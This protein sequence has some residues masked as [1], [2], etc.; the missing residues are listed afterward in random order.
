M[1][2]PVFPSYA[3]LLFEGYGEQREPGLLRTEME[4][5][6]PRQAKVRSRVMRTRSVKIYLATK[7]HFQAFENW[8][9]NELNLGAAWFNFTDPVAK[10]VVMARFVGG[11][12]QSQPLAPGLESWTLTVKIE[13][14]G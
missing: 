8:Y 5:G 1:T 14:W 2:M 11:G 3:K 6:P 12:Y 7:A 9:D 13:S 10:A 4:S